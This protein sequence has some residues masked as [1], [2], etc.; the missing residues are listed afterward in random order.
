M[1]LGVEFVLLGLSQMSA[2]DVR[3]QAYSVQLER[4]KCIF[5]STNGAV[6]IRQR[7]DSERAKTPWMI[8]DHARGT[9]VAFARKVFRK[10]NIAEIHAR[11][12]DGIDGNRNTGFVH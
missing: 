8:R 2:G 5:G 10:F 4:I 9:F 12:G 6:D 1:K 7:Q 3:Q 11:R